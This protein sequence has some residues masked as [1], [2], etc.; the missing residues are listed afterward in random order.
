[1]NRITCLH[2]R[3]TG[4]LVQVRLKLATVIHTKFRATCKNLWAY[5]K[6]WKMKLQSPL[7]SM[8]HGQGSS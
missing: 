3:L 7:K 8:M 5:M 2:N 4:V 1:M 6:Q